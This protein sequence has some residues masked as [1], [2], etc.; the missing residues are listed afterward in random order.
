MVT[1]QKTY[2][3]LQFLVRHKTDFPLHHK[4]NSFPKS[5]PRWL[6]LSGNETEFRKNIQTEFGDEPHSNADSRV[7]SGHQA[8][9][10]LRSEQ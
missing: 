1:Y 6:H 5:G 3:D 8:S 2:T 9:A 10:Q 4:P 7:N